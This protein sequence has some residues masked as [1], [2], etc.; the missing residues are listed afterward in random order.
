MIRVNLLPVKRRKKR[1]PIPP[2]VV[3]LVLVLL[4]MGIG[5]AFT[6]HNLNKTIEQY[7]A[8]KAANDQQI[9]EL[10]RIIKDVDDFE[11]NNREFEQ[12]RKVIED[13]QTYQ[14]APV[15]LV[16]EIVSRMTDNVWLDSLTE[17]QWNISLAGRGYS[18][19]DI[20]AFVESLKSSAVLK[21]VV[22]VQTRRAQEQGVAVYAFT[23]TMRM[24]V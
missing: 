20:V 16:N 15:Q 3:V 17:S 22:L 1:T 9:Q 8:E 19:A 11:A 5:L 23:I 6:T 21:D 12:K 4:L 24:Q 13:L 10:S 2:F 18:N 7:A 14:N